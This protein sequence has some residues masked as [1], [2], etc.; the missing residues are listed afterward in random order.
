MKWTATSPA[1]REM[2]LV[3]PLLAEAKS[4]LLRFVRAE[5]LRF[6]NDRTNRSS[7][8][9]RN[10]IRRQ[11]LPRLRREFQPELHRTVLRAMEVMRSESEFV[12]ASAKAWL[13]TRRRATF[14]SLP[15]AVQRSVIQ[16]ELHRLGIQPQFEWVEKLRQQTGWLTLAAGVVC[17]RTSQ[18]LETGGP[19]KQE[20]Q[21]FELPVILGERRGESCFDSRRIRWRRTRGNKRPARRVA[22]VEFF[23]ARA[24][25]DQ[26]LLRHW[27]PGDRFQPIGFATATKL[28]DVFVNEKVPRERRR[29]LLVATT[30]GGKIFWVEGLRIGEHFKVTVKTQEILRWQ[31]D[32]EPDPGKTTL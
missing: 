8:I 22:N 6:R 16:R 3:R 12:N 32:A 30:A 25:G 17:R 14:E 4:D 24:I 19:E 28:Q 21:P 20:F 1:D 2:T 13:T 29:S 18:G 5:K 7:D 9:L 11:L 26:I 10:R 27:R 31:W 23:D 15:L